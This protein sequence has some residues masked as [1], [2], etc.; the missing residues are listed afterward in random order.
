MLEFR[1]IWLARI[2][3]YNDLAKIALKD[4]PLASLI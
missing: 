3:S 1:A 4:P 2:I